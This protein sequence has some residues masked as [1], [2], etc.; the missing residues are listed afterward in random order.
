MNEDGFWN[1]K[2]IFYGEKYLK[3][4]TLFM[5]GVV[6]LSISKGREEALKS[7]LTI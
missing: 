2:L 1:Y 6:K 4:I 5:R 7:C 3:S